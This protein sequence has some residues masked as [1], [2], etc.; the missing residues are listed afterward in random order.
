MTGAT[1]GDAAQDCGDADRIEHLGWRSGSVA[2]TSLVASLLT[3]AQRV[4]RVDLADLL[5]RPDTR[6]IVVTQTCD[7]V[8]V[9]FDLE[10][11]VEWLLAE[12]IPRKDK[13]NAR[14]KSLR[15]LDVEAQD[16]QALRLH[17]RHRLWTERRAL[18]GIAPDA[19]RSLSHRTSVGYVQ[20]WLSRRYGRHP[21]PNALVERI[22][23]NRDEGLKSLLKRLTE[24]L[25][26]IRIAA[27]PPDAELINGQDYTLE[28]LFIH[29]EP[30]LSE[31]MYGAI[32]DFCDRLRG[33]PGLVLSDPAVQSAE[34]TR[35][36]DL[37]GTSEWL[38]D[39]FTMGAAGEGAMGADP[40][41]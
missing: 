13:Q 5:A 10:P 34:Q 9:R 6:A 14:L 29:R 19:A 35:Y 39:D 31:E 22:D 26:E 41:R 36:S 23:L 1:V 32:D 27:T 17:A 11:H 38:L 28:L 2:P 7:L 21:F 30:Q 20:R 33:K 18:A 12:P 37:R 25:H 40:V 24:E 15:Q 16:G 8:S 3:A 4:D